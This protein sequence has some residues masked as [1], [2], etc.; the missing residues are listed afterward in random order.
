M[1]PQPIKATAH[2]V[3]DYGFV[4]LM[5]GGSIALGLAPRARNLAL[6]FAATQGTINALTDTPV[7]LKRLLRLRTHGWIEAASGPV[8]VGMPLALGAVDEP[9]ERNAWL[10][11][12]GMLVT[13][14]ALTDWQARPSS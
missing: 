3:I 14:Y 10:A 6:G 2:G 13:V 9:K 7:G 5:I 4:A 11:A 8:F 1:P 12:L